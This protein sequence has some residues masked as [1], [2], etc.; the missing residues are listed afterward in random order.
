MLKQNQSYHSYLCDTAPQVGFLMV[1]CRLFILQG[2]RKNIFVSDFSTDVFYNI[3]FKSVY[4]TKT[5]NK[6]SATILPPFL[7]LW[8]LLGHP[9]RGMS[10]SGVGQLYQVPN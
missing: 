2:V 3:S 7:I 10:V 4:L 8:I 6:L 1:S 5:V 9:G